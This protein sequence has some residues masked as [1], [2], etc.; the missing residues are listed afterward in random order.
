MKN[1][2]N[3]SSLRV[4]LATTALSLM[5]IGCGTEDPE[6]EGNHL[7]TVHILQSNK[8]V[9][10]G[11]TINLTATAIDVDG[12][13]LKNKWSFIS[14]PTGSSATLT[15]DT[16]NST[17]FTADKAGEYVIKFSSKDIVDGEGKD[18]ITITAK[19]LGAISNTCTGYTEIAGKTYTT[20]TTLD[21]C[22]K[23]TSSISVSNHALLTIKPGSVLLFENSTGITIPSTGALKAVGTASNPILFTSVQKTAGYWNGVR[24]SYSNDIRNEVAYANI[25]YAGDNGYANLTVDSNSGSTSRLKI[26]NVTLQH[27]STHGFWFDDYSIISDFKNVTSTKN[28]LTAGVLYANALKSLDG[29]SKFTG[30]L[31][32]DYVTLKGS[33]VT[34]D[35]TWNKLT[36]PVYVEDSIYVNKELTI[37]AGS[38]FVFESEEG[39]TVNSKGS[40]TAIGTK[41][42]P[43][44]FTGVQPTAGYWDGLRFSYSNNSKNKLDYVTIKYGGGNG[45]GNLT[46]DSNSG[47]YSR[48]SISNLTLEDSLKH[49]FWFDDYSII[50]NFKNVVS[51]KNTLTAGVLYANALKSL[52]GTSTFTG[53]L[54]DDYVT[55][56]GSSVTE[57]A[58]WN[59]LTAPV[60]VEDSIYVNKELTIKAGSHFIFE[61]EEGLTINSKGS[62]TAIGTKSDLI[63]FTGVQPT[64]GYWSGL[65]F[66][67]SNNEKNKLDYISVE[68]GGGNGYGNL[69]ADSNS[70]SQ[71]R[72]TVTN[73]TFKNGSEYG[74]WLDRYT[75]NNSDIGS[76]N[77]FTNNAK[78]N[79]GSN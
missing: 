5:I 42:S 49:G 10:V 60:Y 7:P 54:G 26:N 58:T 34:E 70:G 40:L 53:N 67:Y 65:R 37:K 68:Y 35:A 30:N 16:K 29:T 13:T 72:L 47:S 78:G 56:K 12:D 55:L 75:I 24:F 76:V 20:D 77:T 31:G 38:Q 6:N 4:V 23:I 27:S 50:S 59:K 39:L 64:A 41:S 44:L 25:E 51:T 33:S 57:D 66:S 9:D 15:T 32:D 45:Y 43:I 8:T 18:T 11:T 69:T 63:L 71:S 2:I 61:S 36:A 1:I 79:I 28:K 62:L 74:I 46:L 52:D 17:S 3:I 21:G 19:E 73:S 48:I 22:F 14:K